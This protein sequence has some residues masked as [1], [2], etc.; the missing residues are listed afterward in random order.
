MRDQQRYV[1]SPT[2]L[3]FW[4]SRRR[5]VVAVSRKPGFAWSDLSAVCS[6][7]A[8]SIKSHTLAGVESSRCSLRTRRSSSH[9]S[10]S[11]NAGA[12]FRWTSD[13]EG[14]DTAFIRQICPSISATRGRVGRSFRIRERPF[15]SNTRNAHRLAASWRLHSAAMT[16]I[17]QL[18]EQ[19]RLKRFQ[20]PLLL[21]E[22]SAFVLPFRFPLRVWQSSA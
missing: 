8:R 22:E 12:G 15:D 5:F 9:A 1:H 13:T 18:V 7:R 16:L 19:P 4:T 11:S 14:P 21:A 6:A 2:P 20:R 10:I 17:G 3:S